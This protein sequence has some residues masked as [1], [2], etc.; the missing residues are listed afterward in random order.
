MREPQK[1]LKLILNH[2]QG[3]P[4]HFKLVIVDSPSVYLNKV[5]PR[6]KIDFLQT[7]KE[8]CGKD[9]TIVMAADSSVFDRQSS[10]RAFAMSDYYLKLRSHDAM[11]ETGQMDTRVIKVLE[12]TRLAGADRMGQSG[13]K[14]EIKPRV[15]I[16]IMPFMRVRI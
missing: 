15:G 9:R 14:F 8:M 4:R 12:V 13:I 11:L 1:S 5:S 16:Q 10:Y 3:L 6:A 7:C 2:I